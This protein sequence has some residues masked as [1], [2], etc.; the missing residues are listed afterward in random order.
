MPCEHGGRHLRL[1][2]H[3]PLQDD[4]TSRAAR[5]LLA[6]QLAAAQASNAALE[7]ERDDLLATLREREG[8]LQELQRAKEDLEE[9]VGLPVQGVI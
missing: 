8:G 5:Q 9:Q 2:S 6:D 4:E 3:A 1:G 7:I